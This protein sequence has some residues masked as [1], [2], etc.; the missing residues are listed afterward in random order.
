MEGHM[1]LLFGPLES[2][3]RCGQPNSFGRCWITGEE[4]LF[5]CKKCGHDESNKLPPIEKKILYI[6]QFALSKMVK[7]K[8]EQFWGELYDRL[9]RLTAS[10]I[11]TCPFSSIHVE[12]SKFDNRLRVALRA[13]YRHIAGDDQFRRPE[14]IEKR[15]LARSLRA[16]MG[17]TESQPGEVAIDDG[18]ER[19]PHRWSDVF[20]VYVDFP[21]SEELI[22]ALKQAKESLHSSMQSL[23]DHWRANPV[24]FDE[25]VE[26][27]AAAFRS[28]LTLYRE[29]TGGNPDRYS[30]M[31]SALVLDVVDW[32]ART[33][34]VIDPAEKAPV[35]ILEGFADSSH[36]RE[37]PCIFLKCRI[38]A[39]IA[40]LVLSPKGSRKPRPG[41]TYDARVLSSYAP[42]CDA[43]FL[44]GGFR[45]IAIDSRIAAQKRLGTKMFSEQARDDFLTYLD[46]L[47]RQV[48]WAHWQ[49]LA[50]IRGI[51][52]RTNVIPT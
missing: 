7:N 1:A 43:M 31:T 21:Y 32:L 13:M 2:C 44:D 10:D 22:S 9:T 3:P 49:S 39:K 35:D 25:Q 41:D 14:D 23:C 46:D 52:T 36:F 45:E 28:A 8:D 6:D 29:Q 38:W 17:C 26:A 11:I 12:E 24:T 5:K 33:V 18:F 40:E 51:E 50:F 48:P 16:Y 20:N 4:L 19:S 34:E 42:Y 30:W 15:Q 27:E 47:E 37:T